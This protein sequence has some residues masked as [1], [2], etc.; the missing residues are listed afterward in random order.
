MWISS[1]S[2][3]GGKREDATKSLISCGENGTFSHA[4][5]L[6]KKTLDILGLEP[7]VYTRREYYQLKDTIERMVSGR[8]LAERFICYDV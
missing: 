7:H 4:Y 3:M 5:A 2:M 1:S 8:S 6:V